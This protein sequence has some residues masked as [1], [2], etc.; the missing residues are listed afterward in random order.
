MK[1]W[2]LEKSSKYLNYMT[3]IAE[4][5]YFITKVCKILMFYWN[6]HVSA[7]TSVVLDVWSTHIQI[8][9]T[10]FGWALKNP[11]KSEI[12]SFTWLNT[13]EENIAILSLHK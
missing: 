1:N 9:Q 12:S 5:K 13:K 7:K 3:W 4:V 2:S 10:F 6:K 8:V 11:N